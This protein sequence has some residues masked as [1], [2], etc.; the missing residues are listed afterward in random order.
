MT[1]LSFKQVDVF[2]QRRFLG[3]PLAVVLDAESLSSAQMQAIA[4]WTNLSETTFVLAPTAPG[5]DY[6]VRIFTPGAELPFAGH[7]TIG[8]AHALLEAGRIAPTGGRLTQQCKAG[9]IALRVDTAPDGAR[10]I[11]LRLPQPAITALAGDETR[12]LHA[13]LGVDKGAPLLVDVGPRWVVLQLPDAAAVLAV[14][15]DLVRMEALDRA[16]GRTGVVLFGA[17]PAGSAADYEMRAFA[18]AHGIAED[19]VCGSGAGC[20]GAFLRHT[21]SMRGTVLLAQG[22]VVGRDG[23]I[24]LGIADDAIDVGGHAVTCID[25]VLTAPA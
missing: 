2:T 25:G 4:N 17:C 5:A 6:Q 8:T 21:S 18:P 10:A 22:Q 3:N 19:P 16:A 15:P 1:Q 20:V 9:L 7:P 12:Q 11:S 13:L 24:R 23:R 14:V